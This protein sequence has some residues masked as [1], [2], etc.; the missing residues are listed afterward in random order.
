MEDTNEVHL[1]L[2]TDTQPSVP[3][4]MQDKRAHAPPRVALPVKIFL[5]LFS[6]LFIASGILIPS[7][8]V[9]ERKSRQNDTAFLSAR[10][11]KL[12]SDLAEIRNKQG[13]NRVVMDLP[14]HQ[15][16]APPAS[17]L[18]LGAGPQHQALGEKHEQIEKALEELSVRVAFQEGKQGALAELRARVASQEKK[19]DVDHRTAMA[20]VVG[21]SSQLQ[22]EKEALEKEHAK[23]KT[24]LEKNYDDLK[25]AAAALDQ[26]TQKQ[27]ALKEKH[28]ELEGALGKNYAHLL[29]Q[30]KW[31]NLRLKQNRKAAAAAVDQLKQQQAALV[32]EHAELKAAL[33]K[34]QQ[35]WEQEQL[36]QDERIETLEKASDP[37]KK[38]EAATGIGGGDLKSG[39][40][41]DQEIS[42][43]IEGC[44][45]VAVARGRAVAVAVPG[46]QQDEVW[47]KII[48]GK[49]GEYELL[50]GNALQ[51]GDPSFV[52]KGETHRQVQGCFFR[53]QEQEQAQEQE[54]QTLKTDKRPPTK[55]KKGGSKSVSAAKKG[56]KPKE[57]TR[58]A[59]HKPLGKGGARKSEGA[60]KSMSTSAA[61][62][63][64]GKGAKK[65]EEST[66]AANR[67]MLKPKG[68]PRATSTTR[69]LLPSQRL[70]GGARA[71]LIRHS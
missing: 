40:D 55:P 2:D 53:K 69:G 17:P 67:P 26:L 36:K 22:S 57:S 45:S 68:S 12:V 16:P 1:P 27:E 70:R 63:K 6:A 4:N 21:V 46:E 23:L 33:A 35:A 39:E 29:R 18:A 60:K 37:A 56:A 15:P 64:E 66:S 19:Q 44:E 3:S 42:P 47:V 32:R 61:K 48:P 11:D 31:Q 34:K 38:P 50:K 65:S 13:Y 51:Q 58:S 41:A 54:E 14:P 25:D 71:A 59:A 8:F 10:L 5:S 28:A 24:A 7:V 49:A 62:K 52:Y 43:G 20:A 30:L 9:M